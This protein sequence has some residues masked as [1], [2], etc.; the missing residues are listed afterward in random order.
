MSAPPYN[1]QQQGVYPEQPGYPPQQQYQP[2]QYPPPGQYPPP[3]Q[4]QDPNVQSAPAPP[5][6]QVHVILCY[7]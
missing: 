5:Y 7:I 3:Q 2:A 1:N 4:G 6:Q